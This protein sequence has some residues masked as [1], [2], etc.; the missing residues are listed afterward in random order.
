MQRVVNLRQ[1]RRCVGDETSCGTC[2]FLTAVPLS[3][4]TVAGCTKCLGAFP[5]RDVICSSDPLLLVQD[6][7]GFDL[8]ELGLDRK[9]VALQ[10]G[11]RSEDLIPDIEDL[12]ER[13]STRRFGKRCKCL[14]LNL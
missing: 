9:K 6:A 12:I 13:G 11:E 5:L 14:H 4:H 3:T 10:T 2:H 8:S 7:E 1:Y